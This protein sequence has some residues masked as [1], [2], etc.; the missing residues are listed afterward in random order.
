MVSYS[1][2]IFILNTYTNP[3]I[4]Q[5]IQIFKNDIIRKPFISFTPIFIKEQQ[6][7]PLQCV[8]KHITTV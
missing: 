6:S 3:E 7:I 5:P 1:T 4:N 2:T 8:F